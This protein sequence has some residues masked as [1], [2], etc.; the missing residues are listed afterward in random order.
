MKNKELNIPKEWKVYKNDFMDLE[1]NNSYP[2]DEV[3]YYFQEDILQAT[4]N[5]YLIDLGFYGDYSNNRKGFFRLIVAKG[6]F[7]E[8]EL[9]EKYISRST[10]EIKNKLEFYFNFILGDEIESL[11]GLKYGEYENQ[12][13][14]D[15]YSSIDKI[16]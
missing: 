8:G 12:V 9:F 14:Y 16:N 11:S 15:I 5:D 10:E 2:I 3:W 7:N 6:D 4:Y 1:P 13:E